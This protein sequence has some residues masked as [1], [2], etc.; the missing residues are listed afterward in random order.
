[1]IWIQNMAIGILS[2][3]SAAQDSH[4]PLNL[5]KHSEFQPELIGELAL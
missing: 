2:G 5:N 3:N 4:Q 1:M